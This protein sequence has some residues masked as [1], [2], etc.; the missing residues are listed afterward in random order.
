M[1]PAQLQDAGYRVDGERHGFVFH[2]ATPAFDKANELIVVVENAF[3]Y[4]SADH[5]VQSGAVSATSQHSNSH[6][7]LLKVAVLWFAH[8]VA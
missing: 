7:S 2:H 4:S 1:V 8:H 3:A 6:V 5:R